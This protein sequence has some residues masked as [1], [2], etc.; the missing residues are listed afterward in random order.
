MAEHRAARAPRGGKG[1]VRGDEGVAVPVASH[2][3]AQRKEDRG[4]GRGGVLVLERLDQPLAH[5]CRGLEQ[6]IFQVPQGVRHLIHDRQA[7]AADLLREPEELDL[8]F[9]LR[10]D[11]AALGLGR[12]V[13]CQETLRHARLEVEDRA[14]CRL[15]GV[16]GE[17]RPDVE[18]LQ[19]AGDLRGA[20]ARFP[21][22]SQRP[23][24]RSTVRAPR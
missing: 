24:D 12:T 23:A 10:L 2:P 15:G 16:R 22:A 3:A 6:T 20:A 13:A 7:V 4:R 14:P 9:Q 5:A 1:G 17:H 21:Q 8:S 19:C 11:R 18:R